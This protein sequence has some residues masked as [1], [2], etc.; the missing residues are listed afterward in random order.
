MPL[1][2]RLDSL[3]RNLFTRP[4]VERDLDDELR[5]HLDHLTA[6]KRREGMDA[7]DARRAACIE[8]GGIE[9]VKE[10]VRQ[11]RTGHMLE[12]LAGDLRY[13]IR[14]LVKT[15]GV[16]LI[17]ILTLM[18]GIG[19]TTAVFSWI[20]GILP[21]RRVAIRRSVHRRHR[22]LGF[23]IGRPSVCA[24]IHQAKFR[25]SGHRSND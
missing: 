9:Q 10:E 24:K 11:I 16:T 12:D 17:A 4:R 15:P 14:M 23:R 22:E 20:E 8:L 6:E 1:L 21:L 2:K 19:A 13:G 5:A 3:Q 7:A 25:K 18:L